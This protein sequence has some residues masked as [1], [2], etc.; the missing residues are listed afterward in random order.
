MD[1]ASFTEIGYKGRGA[2]F[3]LGGGGGRGG[4]RQRELIF[5]HVKFKERM[6]YPGRDSG[7]VFGNAIS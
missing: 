4:G 5:G 6:N 2:D 3:V 1:L 7:S